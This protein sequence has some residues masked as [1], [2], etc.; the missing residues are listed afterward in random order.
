MRRTPGSATEIG[1]LRRP[2]QPSLPKAPVFGWDNLH[3]AAPGLV[4]SIGDLAHRSYTT[5]GRA[6]L[7]QALRQMQLEPGTPVLVPTYHCPTMVAPIVHAGL[8]P[9][10]YPL[11]DDGMPDLAW[12]RAG[13]FHAQPGAL[14]VPHYFGLARSLANTLAWCRASGVLMIEDCAHSYFGVAGERAV[15][16]WGDYATASLSK[17]FPVPEAGLLACATRPLAAVNLAPAGLPQ[18]LK[19]LW[20]VV[21]FGCTQGR[22]SG[23]SQVLSP[24]RYARGRGATSGAPVTAGD[25]VQPSPQAIMDCDMGRRLQRPTAVAVALHRWLPTGRIIARRR[26]NYASLAHTLAGAPGASVMVSRL[27]SGWVPYAMPLWVDGG[28]RA[29]H[30][31]AKLRGERLPVFRWDRIWP[32]TPAIAGDAGARW[33]RHLLQLLCHQDLSRAEVHAFG[34]RIL[35]ALNTTAHA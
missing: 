7:Y 26:E 10:F 29:D 24:L 30:V 11:D 3:R 15:G 23:L 25:D 12:L 2:S 13:A 35:H 28:A 22:L 16:N 34:Q 6:A 31:Y 20:D 8:Q 1:G 27:E 5:S 32:A 18:Q 14:L 21:D 4:P 9:L 33:S 17:F 19:A